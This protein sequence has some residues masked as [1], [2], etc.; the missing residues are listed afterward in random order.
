MKHWPIVPDGVTIKAEG[1]GTFYEYVTV[2]N[3]PGM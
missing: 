1:V 2:L 3:P